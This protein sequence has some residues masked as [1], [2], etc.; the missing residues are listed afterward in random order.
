MIGC[1]NTSAFA[2]TCNFRQK[3]ACE[4]YS[5][6]NICALPCWWFAIHS[7]TMM[8]GSQD[9]LG[10][11]IHCTERTLKKRTWYGTK[12]SAI[13][14]PKPASVLVETISCYTHICVAALS[15]PTPS[16]LARQR[17]VLMKMETESTILTIWIIFN[18]SC[19]NIQFLLE[20]IG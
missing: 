5:S 11:S 16:R 17:T 1:V 4:W 8:Y 6:T 9:V 3:Q 20:K 7:I 13:R 19:F 2:G 15:A 10:S 12:C 18:D 14:M